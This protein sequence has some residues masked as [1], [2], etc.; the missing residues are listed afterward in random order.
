VEEA[1]RALS[2]PEL[3]AI[4]PAELEQAGFGPRESRVAEPGA[5]ERGPAERG[6]AERG[7]AEIDRRAALVRSA[8]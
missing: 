6:A 3:V 4:G 1:T 7:A 8:R 2:A 5:A